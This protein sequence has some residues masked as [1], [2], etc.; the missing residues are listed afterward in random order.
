MRGHKNEGFRIGTLQNQAKTKKRTCISASSYGADGRIR[1][2]DLI[3][4]KDALYR[5]SYIST[6]PF[7]DARL[8]ILH[9]PS[10][11]KGIFKV[12][13]NFTMDAGKE[14]PE[15]TVGSWGRSRCAS[16]KE[17]DRHG[18]GSGRGSKNYPEVCHVGWRARNEATRPFTAR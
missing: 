4:T 13:C 8:I 5:L 3:L 16:M 14:R 2:G 12:Y 6:S 7:L 10:K 9:L 17:A 1:T 11:S 15:G 18:D